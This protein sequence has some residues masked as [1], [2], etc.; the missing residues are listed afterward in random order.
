VITLAEPGGAQMSVAQL[1]PGLVRVAA[2]GAAGRER[3]RQN[4]DVVPFRRAHVE[5]YRRLLASRPE[6]AGARFSVAAEPGE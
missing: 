6:T 3:V 5:L 2:L 1:L 4:F